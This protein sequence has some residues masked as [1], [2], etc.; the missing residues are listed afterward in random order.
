MTLINSLNLE[1]YFGDSSLYRVNNFSV[2]QKLTNRNTYFHNMKLKRKKIVTK[3][4]H[5]PDRESN[6]GRAGDSCE[7]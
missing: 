4:K 5:F 6:P 7:W 3:K 2:K 1:F